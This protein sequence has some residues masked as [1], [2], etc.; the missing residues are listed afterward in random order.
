[1]R[2]DRFTSKFQIAISDAQSLALGRDHQYIEPVHLMVALLD[3]NGS[4]IRPLLT[5]LDVDVSHLRSKL[6]EMLDRLPKVSGIGGDVQLSSSMG[7]LFNL[8]DK[9]AQKR[10]DSY[11]SSEVFLLAALEDRGPL[12]QLLK[13]MGLT[14]QKVSQ[15]IEK[16]RGGQKVN[17]PNAEELRQALEKFTID[18]TE[19][20]EQGKLDP[21]I[22]RDDEIR[23]TIQ[24]L[25]RRTKNN[26]VIIGEPGVGKTAIVEGLAQRII[27]N[28]VPEGL[29]GR[30]VLSLD[31]GALVAGAKYR[32]EFE[33]RL[34]SVLNEL[35]KEEGNVILFIDELHTMVGAGKGEG[36][37]DAG[38]MLKPALARGELHCVGATTLDE[39]RQ[40]IEKDAALERRFQKVLVDE[41][42]VEDTIAIL[43]GLKER[44][45]LHHHV[46]IT[47]PAIVAAASLSHRYVSDRQLPDKAIDLIDEA[48]SSIRLQIDSKPESLDKLERK[49]IQLKIEQQALSNEHDE[50]SEKRLDVLNEELNEK[51]R[52]YAELEEVWNAE[53]AALSGT[54][55]IKGELEQARMDMDFA[56]R[57]GDLNRMSELQYGR[58]PE[59]EKQLD[60]A[61]QA[62]MQEMTLLRNKV[63]DN[64]IAEVLSKQTGIP[65]SKMLEAE[66]E[67][68][69]RM[70]DV[71]HNRV[72][73]QS[74]A[75]E[76]VS[77]AIRRSR[78]GLSDPNKP[79][80]SFLF[81]GPTGV[82]KTELCKTLA[83]FMFDSEDAMVRIDMSE[84]M[85]KHSVARL[86]GAPPGYVGYEEGGYL[87]EAVRRKPYSV[88][89]LDEVEKAHPDVFNILLQ[90]LDD[91]RLTD[92]QGRTVDFRNTV[93]IMTS[94]LGSARIQENFATLDYQGIKNEVMDVVSKHFRPEFLNRVDE[95]VVFHPL[96]Q[97]HI[98]SIAS[99]QL[100][101]LAK[102]LEEKGYQL[103]V[104]DKALDLIAQVGF[105][106][107]YGARPLKRAIQQN[108]ENPLAKSILAGQIL[109][110]KKV[111]LIVSNDQIIAHQ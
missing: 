37:M 39:Y 47:D 83:S 98:K 58:I 91:G 90:V 38:N 31:M 29:R 8:C 71:L 18:L 107:V 9:V 57:A 74:E 50:A 111:Q 33:E 61:T 94:N 93:V 72:V 20:A 85:E 60:L 25:Q 6:S 88:I 80:G 41:P 1:M 24:V 13:E 46:E 44:Y 19:R 21:V 101:R 14:E 56:R 108:V 32:G 53:K 4:P 100:E 82:G 103:E 10:Q 5:M 51:E 95:S 7:T 36:S 34:K 3:Q 78:A 17:D 16:I 42:S 59:L 45:E 97:E 81:L 68:L 54:Q 2:L 73:G 96:G 86:V 26:P 49:I 28:E 48:A 65:V 66:K 102:R 15:A 104:S 11:I 84:F 63:T 105:D 89:L 62:E 12:G 55:H 77:N 99:I 67:K 27:N 23:R 92:G 30:R 109:P 70:E 69:L 75:V 43:R 106:P 76:V 22:G 79:I 35:A 52:E 40:Y 64:E 87:T 110:D